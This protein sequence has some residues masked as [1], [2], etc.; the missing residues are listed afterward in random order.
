L[1]VTTWGRKK[2]GDLVNIEIDPLARYVARLLE[3]RR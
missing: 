2:R 1:T 3:M